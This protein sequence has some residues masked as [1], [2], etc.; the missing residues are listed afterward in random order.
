MVTNHHS[1]T[2]GHEACVILL[3]KIMTKTSIMLMKLQTRH[4][5]HPGFRREVVLVAPPHFS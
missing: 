2:W 4:D 1:K 3:V 5:A